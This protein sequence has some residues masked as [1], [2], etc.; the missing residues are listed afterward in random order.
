MLD[1]WNIGDGQ[2]TGLFDD[3]VPYSPAPQTIIQGGAPSVISW[4]LNHRK[5]IDISTINQ[6][7]IGAM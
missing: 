5:S 1:H 4:F 2:E 6:S 7:E 3:L